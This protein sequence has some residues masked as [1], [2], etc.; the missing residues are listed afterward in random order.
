MKGLKKAENMDPIFKLKDLLC[1]E[2][3]LLNY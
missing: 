2:N 1:I 3:L